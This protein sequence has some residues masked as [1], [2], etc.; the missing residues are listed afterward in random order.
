MKPA[1]AAHLVGMDE[2]ALREVNKI[3]A[4][5]VIKSGSTLLVPRRGGGPIVDVS[6]TVADNAT[7]MLAP[8][9]PPLRKVTLRAGK[10][11]SVA[12]IARRYRVSTSQVAQWNDVGTGATFASGQT[13]VVYVAA[14][15]RA[16][17]TRFAST[18][19]GTK[20][21]HSTHRSDAAASR[22]SRTVVTS[23][24]VVAKR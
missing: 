14:K 20:V 10:H 6:S 15:G 2:E 5:M 13:I 18:V 21:A 7:I 17:S 3:P 9:A 24:H 8:D 16:T 22:G 4:R 11:D 1:E 12:T 23:K 19:H